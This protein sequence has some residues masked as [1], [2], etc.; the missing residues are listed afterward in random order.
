MRRVW[1]FLICFLA[2]SF[3]VDAAKSQLDD[4]LD[5]I[6]STITVAP[7]QARD[8]AIVVDQKYQM[9]TQPVAVAIRYQLLRSDL[10]LSLKL[11]DEATQYAQVGLALTEL[12]RGYL[13]QRNALG[14]NLVKS[15]IHDD[16]P[17]QVLKIIDQLLSQSDSDIS[18]AY[19]AQLLLFKV[20][21]YQQTERADLSLYALKAA[22]QLAQSSN[23]QPLTQQIAVDLATRL[24][25]LNDYNQA[26]NLLKKSDQYYV[27]NQLSVENLIVQIKLSELAYSRGHKADALTILINAKALALAVDSGLFR[28]VI[29]LR[30]AELELE[31]GNIVAAGA[32]LIELIKLQT[33]ARRADDKDRLLLIR[34]RYKVAFNDFSGLNKLLNS[35]GALELNGISKNDSRVLD[36]LKLKAQGLASQGHFEQA[37]QILQ[38]HQRDFTTHSQR[39]N[40]DSLQRQKM[41]FDLDLLEQENRNLNWSNVLQQSELKRHNQTLSQLN[42]LLLILALVAASAISLAI[43][44]YQ[45][46]QQLYRLTFQDPLTGIHNRR[47]LSLIFK[48][49]QDKYIKERQPLAALMLDL[50]KFKLVNDRYGHGVGDEV[51]IAFTKCCKDVLPPEAILIRLGGEEVLALLPQWQCI[52]ATKIAETLRLTLSRILIN[53]GRGNTFNFTTSI[54]VASLSPSVLDQESLLKLADQRLYIAKAEGRNRVVGSEKIHCEETSHLAKC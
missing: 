26:E 6:E 40:T 44:L 36:L 15:V 3:S 49:L 12:H 10:A 32:S 48:Q 9:S 1:Y 22:Y 19:H 13:V 47:Y 20:K 39:R 45:K 46:R 30:I 21:I 51:I 18:P 11:S 5:Q 34:A 14:L 31:S 29:E 54:G 43:L 8:M 37:Y 41:M 24:L 42:M 4:L 23:N 2:I 52:E 16:K 7:S 53:T 33:H 27:E 38:Q 25:E 35:H 50:D 17:L 28:F